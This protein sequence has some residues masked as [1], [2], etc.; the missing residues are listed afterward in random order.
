MTKTRSSMKILACLMAV[1]AVLCSFAI[2][3]SALEID[4]EYQPYF[5]NMS[6]MHNEAILKGNAKVI[7]EMSVEVD[8]NNPVILYGQSVEIINVVIPED[9][10]SGYEVAFDQATHSMIVTSPEDVPYTEF[11]TTL[12][13]TYEFISSGE[14]EVQPP[15]TTTV[16][17]VFTLKAVED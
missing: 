7:D 16:N 6:A 14:G 3:A 5:S 15:H 11:T 12:A 1:V 10:T 8:F 4:Q 2:S 13:V 17:V 9:N